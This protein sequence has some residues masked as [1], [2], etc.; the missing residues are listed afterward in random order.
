MKPLSAQ[1][2]ASLG[3]DLGLY[4]IV[5][6]VLSQRGVTDAESA[7]RFINPSITDDW[8]D[9][10]A[11]AGMT[12]VADSLA[13]ALRAEKRITIFGDYDVDGITASAIM[14]NTLLAL[15]SESR[16]VL[17]LR[18][19][20]GY[21]LSEAALERIL[22][23][24]PEVVLTV[25]CG[26]TAAEEITFLQEQG[27]EVLV[28]DHHE[29][30]DALIPPVPATDPKLDSSSPVGIL[31][32][33]G[34]ALK[35]AAAL[36]ARFDKPD[37][38]KSQ[39][40][41]AA[42]G[43][44]GDSMPLVRENRSLV[45]AGLQAMDAHPRPGMTALQGISGRASQRTSAEDL[46]YGLIPRLNAAGRVS[47]PLIAFDLLS[48][49]NPERALQLATRLEGLN[50]ERRELEAE[51]LSQAV[52]QIGSFAPEQKSLVVGGE[53]WHE[54][55]KG[56]VANRLVQ[57][58][59]VPSIV[60]SLEDG[61][62]VGSG[63][64][65]GSINLYAAISQLSSL[66]IR[67]G[68]HEAA[69]GVTLE[70]DRLDEFAEG[71]EALMQQVPHEQFSSAGEIDC[72]IGFEQL[73]LEAIDELEILEPYGRENPEPIFL[74]R[75]LLLK[76]PRFVGNGEKHL[77]FNL[78]DGVR[79][80]Q[81][82]WFNA[83]CHKLE[84][85]PALVDVVYHVRI[86]EW[87]GKRRI[88]L[89][90]LDLLTNH[91]ELLDEASQKHPAE[92]EL[93]QIE[94]LILLGNRSEL[95]RQI[96]NRISGRE[97]SLRAAQLKCLET[98][99]QHQ[100]TLAIMATGRGKSLIFQTY[101]ATLA[102]KQR[103]PSLFI[104]PLRSLISDQEFFL[105]GALGRLGLASA[106]LTGATPTVERERIF[107]GVGEGSIQ[108]VLSTPEFV[109]ANAAKSTIW[110]HFSFV[111]IDEAHH[112]ATSGQDFRPDY[113][114]LERLRSLVG[115]A[116]ILGLSATSDK[117]T[118]DA[119]TRSLG[120]EQIVVDTSKR[121]NL[122]L[123]DQRNCECREEELVRIVAGSSRALVYVSSRVAS[124]ELCK[125]LRKQLSEKAQRIAFYNAALEPEDRRRVEDAF[126]T[127][128]LD[129][130]IATSAFGEGVNIPDVR[131][132]VLYDLPYSL[133]DFNQMAGRAGRDG[134]EAH[135]H[136]LAERSDT[137]YLRDHLACEEA[138]SE[139]ETQG[140]AAN[141]ERQAQD[142][143]V[144]AE[145]QTSIR[146]LELFADWL[147]E[148]SPLQVSSV[149]QGPL[150]PLET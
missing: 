124:I 73:S 10:E 87:R 96:A 80:L 32:G 68:G 146:Q 34:V 101:A 142:K 71:L 109:L 42:L 141:D 135:I 100:S 148:A 63:R 35:L 127:G 110:S 118:T 103:K 40:D 61:I 94:Q 144:D 81:A 66:L 8:S 31:A 95:N 77:S 134:Q 36:G 14:H 55:V 26:I 131:D 115:E 92:Q 129:C 51:L 16:I 60:F 123:D 150:T 20:E 90:V 128:D 122:L 117:P 37:L 52:K 25:D 45:A 65:V 113:T 23:T 18:E 38:W 19:G 99:E 106:S 62:A 43:T 7:R 83:S 27:I 1:T 78:S 108:V 3:W 84:D 85:L 121:P 111:V 48:A 46:S 104:Y 69:I 112:I 72:Q 12:E 17:P 76:A 22:E 102:L 30:A 139:D 126:R 24:Q 41:L 120:I 75:G 5:A 107:K 54:G 132:V 130:L 133:I 79:E 2:A 137:D 53:R 88:K 149:I 119:I 21:G 125:L 15:G 4:R 13:R 98:L 105:A 28:T 59:G 56:I 67:F 89:Y 44:L 49:Q 64:S 114:R 29:P 86:D 116:V 82:I 6:A 70:Q 74:T 57:E 143:T 39:I 33:A 138:P 147:F 9:P 145:R 97:V 140:K 47:D 93:E 136:I 58:Y 11:I 91:S 50:K